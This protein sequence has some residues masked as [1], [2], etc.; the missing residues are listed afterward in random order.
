MAIESRKGIISLKF[1]IWNLKLPALAF[2]G[3]R[4]KSEQ[5][6]FHTFWFTNIV[7]IKKAAFLKQLFL[8]K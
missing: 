5:K 6:T 8:L 7:L 1:G 3:D 2:I 4:N